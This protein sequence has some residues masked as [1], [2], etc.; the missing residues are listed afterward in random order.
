MTDIASPPR[1]DDHFIQDPHALYRRLQEERPVAE[2]ITPEQSRAWLITR[3]A[4]V[5][6]ALADPRLSKDSRQLGELFHRR[7]EGP[8]G[9]L[10]E[11]SQHMLNT[12]PPDHARLR[13]LV[14]K[15]F[16]A[17]RV[18]LLRPRIEAITSVLLDR[19]AG[20]DEV[21]LL[22]VLAV[23]LPITV[24]CE[25]LGVPDGDRDDFRR[26]SNTLLSV[27][28]PEQVFRDAMTSMVGYLTELALSKREHPADDMLSALVE[29]RDAEDRLTEGELIST[30]FLLLVAGHETT[31]NLI[32]N[33]MLALLRDPDQLAALRADRS[34]LSGAVEEF[35]RYEGPL[36]HATL[37][38]T[39]EPVTIGGVLIPAD[40]FVIVAVGAANRDPDRYPEPDQLDIGRDAG[41]H[42]A[43]GHGIH[44][45]LGAPLARLEAQIA[46][47]ALLDRFEYLA[48]AV[49][50][51]ALRWRQSSLIRGLTT[52]PVRLTPPNQ[53]SES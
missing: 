4:D 38:F 25:L 16:T 2:V 45:C 31:V 12:D 37:R 15:A 26:W 41:G 46:F 50:P 8:Q 20:R 23:P 5:R 17:R 9:Y 10:G 18:E 34:L 7:V 1:M 51:D 29:A 47:A 48:L 53:G 21:D 33:G 27:G 14:N 36:N 24:I 30:A 40:E 19:I 44:Y 22:D 39:A 3:Y 35:L 32:G 42:M 49:E 13:T 11:L 6:A 52:L 28:V 43:F